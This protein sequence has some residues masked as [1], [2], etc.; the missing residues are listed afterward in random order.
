MLV[1]IH[2]DKDKYETVD[3]STEEQVKENFTSITWNLYAS[4]KSG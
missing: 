1:E 4:T 3:L 2:R